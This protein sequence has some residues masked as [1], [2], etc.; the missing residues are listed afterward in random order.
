[1]SDAHEPVIPRAQSIKSKQTS[2]PLIFAP[3]SVKQF[4]S[5]DFTLDSDSLICL[6]Q[7]GCVLILFYIDNEESTDLCQIWADAS[8][9]A[10]GPIFG[11]CHM[12]LEQ[13]V[14]Q[15]F[16]TVKGD[17]NNPYSWAGLQQY[18]FI[19]VYRNGIPQAFYNGER[20]V[21]PIINFSLI[22][23]CTSSYKEQKQYF[24]GMQADDRFGMGLPRKMEKYPSQSEEF[25]ESNHSRGFDPNMGLEEYG[26]DGEKTGGTIKRGGSKNASKQENQSSVNSSSGTSNQS[27]GTPSTEAQSQGTP[28]PG[29]QPQVTKS[30]VTPEPSAKELDATNLDPNA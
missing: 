25:K 22:L 8:S 24:A 15:A 16:M 1:M 17:N 11:A 19:L 13:D 4:R 23:A 2:K 5:S 26:V 3:Q 29:T 30:T 21:E 12:N 18:P 27:Q 9:E 28:S 10:S 14:A 7:K 20:S 6:K